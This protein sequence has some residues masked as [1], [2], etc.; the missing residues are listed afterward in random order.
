MRRGVVAIGAVLWLAA[1]SSA[2]AGSSSAADD[3][4]RENWDGTVEFSVSAASGNTDNSVLGARFDGRRVLGRYTHDVKAAAHYTETT[5][6]VDGEDVT[7]TTQNVWFGE[8]RL[9]MQTG[10]RTFAYARTRYTEDTFSGYDRRA[11]LGGGVGHGIYERDELDWQ[12]L[13]GPG[14]QYT[15]YVKPETPEEDFERDET[16]VALFLGSDFKWML[17]ENVE[18]EHEA[19]ATWTDKNSTLM[20]RLSLK[21][22]IT[23]TIGTRLGYYVK[24]E[25]DPAEETEATDTQLKASIVFDY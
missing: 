3:K 21:T 8:Y 6:E 22:K 2:M 13:A 4:G 25:T 7:E 11:F 20:S 18:V 16:Q 15:Q 14:V 12:V 17:R 1:G 23:E 10:D 5:N 9:E 24:H 19:D